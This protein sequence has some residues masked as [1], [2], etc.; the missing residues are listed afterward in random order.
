MFFGHL[1]TSLMNK[2]LLITGASRGIGAATALEA[3]KRG[4]SVCINYRQSAEAAEK[5]LN[6]INL[7]GGK[8]IAVR[9]DVSQEPEV[10]E[11][12]KT[13]DK[14]LNPLTALVNNA[15]YTEKQ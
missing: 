14:T 15:D 13:V 4:Y 6:Q 3:A 2:V 5:I 8:A 1:Y 11:L 12:F 9:A 10:V 7:Q